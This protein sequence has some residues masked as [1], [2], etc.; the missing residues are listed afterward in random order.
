MDFMKN[1]AF[2]AS[3]GRLFPVN[4]RFAKMLCFIPGLVILLLVL[5]A[6]SVAQGPASPAPSRLPLM[7]SPAD[8]DKVIYIQDF[9]VDPGAFKQDKGGITGKGFL[10]PPPPGFPTRKLNDS[11]AEAQKLVKVM[12]KSLVA[13]LRKAGLS[14]IWLSPTEARP[15][16]GLVVSGVFTEM[17]EGN[18]MR[19]ALIGFGAG[20]SKI[21]LIVTVA[22]ASH[23][24]Q[25][26]YD[27]ATGKSSGKKPGTIVPLN[28]YLGAAGF[29]AK[30][31]ITKNAPERMI[32][33]TASQIA[34]ELNKQLNYDSLVAAD[35]RANNHTES[36]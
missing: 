3:C 14:V 9:E 24:E 10:V 15:A 5:A 4:S 34:S 11:A 22:D 18:Q 13:D 30:F 26:R 27:V 19:R 36:R 33:K 31:A 23:P 20:A 16:E 8:K 12:S 7:L 1:N 35:Q 21:E 6:A 29:V 2:I 25:S 17:D 28:P 32:K